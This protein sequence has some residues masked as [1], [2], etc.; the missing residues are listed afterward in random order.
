M[1]DA[2]MGDSLGCKDR[3]VFGNDF[4]G[5]DNIKAGGWPLSL[6]NGAMPLIDRRASSGL[7]P[8]GSAE[9]RLSISTASARNWRANSAIISSKPA[10]KKGSV[11]SLRCW[12]LTTLRSVRWRRS[13]MRALRQDLVEA[14]V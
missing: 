11:S 1:S 13:A 3:F 2:P 7:L 10:S 6:A 14:W 8:S 9:F 5:D 12:L 4:V